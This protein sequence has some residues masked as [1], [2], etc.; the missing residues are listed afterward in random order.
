MRDLARQV[1]QL[2]V[3][4][5]ASLGY[6]LMRAFSVSAPPVAPLPAAVEPAGEHPRELLFEIG[7]EEL[8]V[9]DLDSAIQQLGE[10]MADAL[11]AARLAYE[12]LDVQGTPR[13]LVV[14]VSG[15]AARQQDVEQVVKGP[16]SIAYDATGAPTR[17]ALGLR[18]VGAWMPRLQQR[19]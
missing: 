5:R 15:M 17:A 12:S 3:A 10:G 1:A 7:V 4:Q 14:H 11:A 13:R 8:P 2:T 16:A 18:G 9:S 6:P 19:L